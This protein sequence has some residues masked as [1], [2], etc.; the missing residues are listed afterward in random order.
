MTGGSRHLADITIGSLSAKDAAQSAAAGRATVLAARDKAAK[1]GTSVW[2]LAIEPGGRIG[3]EGQAC[4]AALA[5]DAANYGGSQP[6]TGRR[7]RLNDSAL[8]MELEG[9]RPQGPPGPRR[10]QHRCPRLGRRHRA[11]QTGR[12]GRQRRPDNNRRN[13][14][15]GVKRGVHSGSS[16]TRPTLGAPACCRATITDTTSP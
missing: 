15:L 14:R 4:L 1:Y 5:R 6:G 16:V 12:Q 10:A 3:A 8:R 11:R 2:A 7:G 13:N 9:R